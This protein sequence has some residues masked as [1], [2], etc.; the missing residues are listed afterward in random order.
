MPALG[1]PVASS[2][3]FLNLA[4]ESCHLKSSTQV[5]VL[6]FQ[7]LLSFSLLLISFQNFL[8]S[9]YEKYV[10]IIKSRNINWAEVLMLYPECSNE[11]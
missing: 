11:S 5:S 8:Y 10:L 4:R 1:A 9:D 7:L 3:S 2:S 6:L